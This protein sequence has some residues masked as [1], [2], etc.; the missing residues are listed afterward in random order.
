LELVETSEIEQ[1][2][3]FRDFIR[4]AKSLGA[5]IAIDDFGAGYSNFS[6]LLEME[7]DF[8]KIDASLIRNLVNDRNSQIVVQTIAGFARSLGIRTVAEFVDSKEVHEAVLGI[9]IDYCQGYYFGKPE[10]TLP[11]ENPA[12]H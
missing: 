10:P 7:V 1:N 5:R 12:N 11:G 2:R 3:E 8:I 6:Y 4:Q 9:G